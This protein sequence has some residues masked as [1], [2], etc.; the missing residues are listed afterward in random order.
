[1]TE[2]VFFIAKTTKQLSTLDRKNTAALI[3]INLYS[4]LFLYLLIQFPESSAK[5]IYS[6]WK[7]HWLF[8]LYIMGICN[9]YLS[10]YFW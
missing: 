2:F 3:E 8:Y 7:K 10:T 5:Y 6:T 1:M 4:V 9:V